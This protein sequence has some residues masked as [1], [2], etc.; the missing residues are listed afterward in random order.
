M[1]LGHHLPCLARRLKWIDGLAWGAFACE[2]A[3]L[4]GEGGLLPNWTSKSLFH[5][6]T[7][8]IRLLLRDSNASAFTLDRKHGSSLSEL[9]FA[10]TCSLEAANLLGILAQA[11]QRC[12]REER[13]LFDESCAILL[14]RGDRDSS[15]LGM[16]FGMGR[17]TAAQ[18]A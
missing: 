5:F 11:G 6:S 17:Q 14:N 3:G 12:H 13:T 10:L 2:K 1:H 4:H 18:G 8:N 7:S 15:D 9:C 16:L